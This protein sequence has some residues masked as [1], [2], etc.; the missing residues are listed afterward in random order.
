MFRYYTRVIEEDK[1]TVK[2]K[3]LRV[4]RAVNNGWR[5]TA[6]MQ[7]TRRAFLSSKSNTGAGEIQIKMACQKLV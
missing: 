6:R 3:A 2:E 4:P 5:F 1:G 7:V